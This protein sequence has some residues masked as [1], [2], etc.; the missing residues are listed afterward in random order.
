MTSPDVLDCPEPE[1]YAAVALQLQETA[2]QAEARLYAVE[3]TLRA[4][5]NR[6]TFVQ[7]TTAA[8]TGLTTGQFQSISPV[9]V[10]NTV[11]FNNWPGRT[12]VTDSVF[13]PP[14]GGL[15]QVGFYGNVIASGAVTDNSYRQL[16]ISQTRTPV[17]EVSDVTVDVAQ[18]TVFEANVGGG[19]DIIV[20]AVFN[21]INGDLFRFELDHSNVGS[22]LNVSSGAIYWVTY[23]G[24]TSTVEV[25]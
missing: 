1:N 22:T 6:F 20:T 17:G 23:L 5:A 19:M 3:R 13:N 11:N 7:T 10:A 24:S 12:S 15:Y 21:A 4:A 8:I 9:F 2:L 16:R 18:A 25:F 14:G